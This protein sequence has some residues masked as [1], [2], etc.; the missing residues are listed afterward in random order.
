ML[1]IIHFLG[2]LER[3]GIRGNCW[4]W[5]KSYLSNRMQPVVISGTSSDWC[6]IKNCVPQGSISGLLL[7]LIYINDPPLVCKN[8]EILLFADNTNIEAVGCS[9]ENIKSDLDSINFSLESNKLVLNLSKTTQLNL[10]KGP[11]NLRFQL[12]KTDIKV[13]HYCKYLGVK[14][15]NKFS[16]RA[17]IDHVQ[18]KL[19]KQSTSKTQTLCSLESTSNCSNF[20]LQFECDTTSSIWCL[21]LWLL[22]LLSASTDLPIAEKNYKSNIF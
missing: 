2:K 17:H 20:L 4:K 7:L 22:Y 19:S 21:G 5:F 6:E 1:S 14:I 13:E 18:S 16:F 11:A 12:N 9:V 10:K 15:D 8:V 3:Y